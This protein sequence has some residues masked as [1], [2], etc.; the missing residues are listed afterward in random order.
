M[1]AE[2]HSKA[3]PW[4]ELFDGRER[5]RAALNAGRVWGVHP[6]L[7][8]PKLLLWLDDRPGA[9]A[10][11][12]LFIS[13]R[14]EAYRSELRRWIEAMRREGPPDGWLDG[15]RATARLIVEQDLR[16]VWPGQVEA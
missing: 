6:Y 16:P 7:H 2:I 5:L 11:L 15:P 10:A 13:E 4:F 3:M 14:D 12:S 1:E 9:E 8:A